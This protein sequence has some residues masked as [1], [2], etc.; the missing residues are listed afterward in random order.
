MDS[1]NV[2]NVEQQTVFVHSDYDPELDTD[3][4]IGCSTVCIADSE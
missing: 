3:M 1:D 4:D 2:P